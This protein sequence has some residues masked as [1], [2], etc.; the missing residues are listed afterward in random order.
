MNENRRDSARMR[1]H[2]KG[3]VS[4]PSGTGEFKAGDVGCGGSYDMH[5]AVGL[6]IVRIYILISFLRAESLCTGTETWQS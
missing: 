2:W 4:A 5:H 6:V 3:K 1:E